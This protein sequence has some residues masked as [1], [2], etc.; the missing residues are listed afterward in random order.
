MRVDSGLSSETEML[1]FH[2]KSCIYDI[3][4][5]NI[6]WLTIALL[7]QNK[8]MWEDQEITGWTW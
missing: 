1:K 7:L 2:E 8:G 4:W 3:V 5:S 6:D